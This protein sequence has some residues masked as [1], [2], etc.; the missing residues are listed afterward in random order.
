[1]R[2]KA[3]R[4]ALVACLGAA[5]CTGEIQRAPGSGSATGGPPAGAA[6]AVATTGAGGQGNL[7]GGLPPVPPE[8][9]FK[10]EPASLRRLTVAQYENSVRDVFGDGVTVTTDLEPDTDLSGF[11]SI[12]ASTVGLSPRATEQFETASLEVA[13]KGLADPV[14]RMTLGGCAPAGMSTTDDACTRA[15]IQKIGRRAWRRPLT[16]EETGR[17]VAVAKNAQTVLGNFVGGLE[18]GVAGLLQSPNFLYR[19]ELGA[20]DAKD[21]AR[22]VYDDYE[23]ATRLSYFLW[24]TTPDDTLLAAA[25]AR[26]LGGPGGLAAQA[27]RLL[28]SPRASAGMQTFFTELYHLGKLDSMP[29]LPAR[30]PLVTATL[31]ASMRMETL[32][33]LDDLAFVRDADFREIFDGRATFVN[34]E[35]AKLYGLSGITGTAF[36]P[37]MLPEAGMRAGLLG[38]ASLL[39]VSSTPTRASATRRGKFIREMVLCQGIPAAPPGIDPLPENGGGTAKQ[40][41]TAHRSVASCAA[42]HVRMDPIG[43][44]LENFDAIGA[45]RTMDAG[46][47]IDASGDLDGMAFA[48]PRQ[49][50]TLLRD[51]PNSASCLARNVFRYALG[52]LEGG[53]EEGA[54]AQVT[55]GYTDG[56]YR[57]RALLTGVVASPSF[58]YAAKGTP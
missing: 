43:L 36:V 21:V 11:T 16:E 4:F 58:V 48:T 33:F 25:D 22:V 18:Y 26:Q 37:T 3:T 49:L 57:F 45:F 28:A 31:G 41:L 10:P 1:M 35:L 9:V 53:G 14:R 12:G 23:L 30:F 54:I 52:H 51:H 17:F 7:G 55:K 15:F 2:S 39:S 44:A 24:N 47:T 34:G 29:Q 56:G 38:Q 27:Q 46:Q 8:L 32:R 20:A 19:V 5:A 40:K 13:K 6:G 42:C 50:A